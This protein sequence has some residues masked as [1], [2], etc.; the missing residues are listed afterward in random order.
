MT[1][2]AP[3]SIKRMINSDQS[4]TFHRPTCPMKT[5][6]GYTSQRVAAYGTPRPPALMAICVAAFPLLH[7]SKNKLLDMSATELME[8]SPN[9]GDGRAGQAAAGMG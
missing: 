1:H 3:F 9:F 4:C 2:H 5:P 8:L 6:L 7:S